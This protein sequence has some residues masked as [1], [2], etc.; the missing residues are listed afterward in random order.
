[1]LAADLIKWVQPYEV[2]RTVRI[3]TTLKRRPPH[4]DISLR[5]HYCTA[6]WPLVLDTKQSASSS[7]RSIGEEQR[8]R[9]RRAAACLVGICGTAVAWDMADALRDERR[10]VAV[11]ERRRGE[12]CCGW[13]PTEPVLGTGIHIIPQGRRRQDASV[14]GRSWSDQYAEH[15][16]WVGWMELE[17]GELRDGLCRRQ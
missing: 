2:S 17:G 3:E 10:T 16:L 1:M 5:T 4:P 8:T 13:K 12:G 11:G 6:P 9:G 15:H 14:H 7:T